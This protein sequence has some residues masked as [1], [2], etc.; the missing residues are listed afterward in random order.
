MYI[1]ISTAKKHLNID[2]WFNEDND[3]ILNLIKVAEDATEKRIGKKLSEC[4]DNSGELM[5]SV[6]QT[7][8]L[9]LGT[10]Y[11]Q[12]EATTPNKISTVPY[13]FDFLASLNQRYV[14]N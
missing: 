8:L 2:E 1:N 12:R 9:L 4:I 11:S 14:I 10:L 3:Y 7:I 13:T 5:P 6:Q